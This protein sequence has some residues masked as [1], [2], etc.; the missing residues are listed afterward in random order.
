MLVR[1]VMS[2]ALSAWLLFRAAFA[3]DDGL[4][5]HWQFHGNAQ[6]SSVHARHAIG[7]GVDFQA[8]G[9]G[10]QAG[11]A[12]GFDGRAS[13]LEVPAAM[14][15][16]LGTSDFSV[17]V[18]VHVAEELDDLPGEIISRYD[19]ATRTG[20]R[21][22]IDSR[23]GVTSSQA[24]WQ[25]VHFGIDSGTEPGEWTDH[26]R[27]GNAIL[28]FALSVHDGQ[29]FAGTCEAGADEAGRVF[30]FDGE[31]WHDCGAPVRCNSVSSLAVYDGNLYV[32]SSKYRLRGSALAESE[33]PHR[34]GTVFRY[35][36][37]DHWV[38]CGTLP[39]IEAINGLVVFRGKLYASSLYAPAG[40]FRYEGG[41]TWT[42]CGVPDG[43]RVESL[44]VHDGHIYAS[45]YDEGAVY[46]FDGE[47]WE[48]L[49]RIEGATQTYGFATYK[50]NLYVS[51]WPHAKVFRY[52]GGRTWHDVGQLGA[53]MESMPLAVY[54]GKM[55]AGTLPTAEVYRYDGDANWKKIARLDFTPDVTYRRVWSMAV[56][57]G[58]LFAGTLPSGHVHSVEIG[59]NVTCDRSLEP[60]WHHIAAVRESGHL[61][62]F[63]DGQLTATSASFAPEE[64]VLTN[65][66]PLRIGSGT[67]DHFNGRLSDLRL[68]GRAL[69]AEEIRRLSG[70]QSIR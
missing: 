2:T 30:R 57:R 64:F 59:R 23:P 24:N 66:Q 25:N 52:G 18:R 4:I 7:E 19:P 28:I 31:Q 35:E 6:D 36:G 20:F 54:N 63:I 46:R 32:A 14:L 50:S 11:T 12:A 38:S 26:G 5:G 9:P 33:N 22:G 55:Y 10:G 27:L 48:H 68:Y 60:G 45:G 21:L 3:A 70:P 43:K 58:R 53:E 16:P 56:Y 65:G 44:A 13:K 40:F 34:G 1:C 37:D 42:S 69:G 17:L 67:T 41:T 29:L 47:T 62:L 39:E 51:E 8:A 15:P 49:G 61:R